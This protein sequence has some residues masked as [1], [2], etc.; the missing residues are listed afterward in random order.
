MKIAFAFLL[1]P[2]A[3]MAQNSPLAK[4]KFFKL[5][6]S[7]RGVY[8]IDPGLFSAMGLNPSQLNPK[9]VRLFAGQQGMLPEANAAKRVNQLEEIPLWASGEADGRLDAGDYFLFFA[10]SPHRP[11]FDS[12][13][14]MI[15]HQQ[16]IYSELNYYFLQ[17]DSQTDGLRMALNQENVSPSQVIEFYDRLIWHEKEETNILQ[18]GRAWYGERFGFEK[19]LRMSYPVAGIN[20]AVAV[21]C[22]M[23]VMGQSF[24]DSRFSLIFNGQKAGEISL[25]VIF[26]G[27]YSPKGETAE[28]IFSLPLANSNRLDLE[29]VFE[30]NNGTAFLDYFDINVS[31]PLRLEGNQ[32]IFS[33]IESTKFPSAIFRIQ[34]AQQAMVWDI[35]NPN[36]PFR[37]ESLPQ[38][39]DLEIRVQTQTFREFVAVRGSNF[40]TPTFS[41]TVANQNLVGLETP[42]LLVIVPDVF[43]SQAERLAAFRRQNDGLSVLLVSPEQIYNEFSSGKQDLVAIRDFVKHLYDK[44]APNKPLRYVLLFGD[45][46]YDFKNRLRNNTNFIPVFESYKSL[47]P[48]FS[49]SSDDFIGLLEEREG[50]WGDFDN[51]TVDVGIG[52]LPVSTVEEANILVDKLIAYSQDSE[53]RG[54]WRKVISFVADDGDNNLHQIQADRL[55]TFVDTNYFNIN[56]KKF[57]VDAFPQ[58]SDGGERRSPVLR[59]VLNNRVNAGSLIV[60]FTGHGAEYGW[61]SEGILDIYSIRSWRNVNRLPFFVTATCEFGRYDDPS[62]RSGAEEIIIHPRGGGIGLITTTRPVFA[63]TNYIVNEAFYRIALR[64]LPNGEM[65]RLGDLVRLTKN[66]SMSGDVNRNFALLGDPSMRLAYPEN[67]VAITSL[68]DKP[69]TGKDTLSALQK[70][71][72]KGEIQ[73]D[74]AI[75]KT[76]FNG[77]VFLQLFEKQI[78][79]TTLGDEGP[80]MNYK[81]RENIIFRGTA[82]V[83][84]GEYEFNFLIPK[85]INYQ[86]GQ[87]RI[88]L[89]AKSQNSDAASDNGRICI[90]SG[91]VEYEPD[92]E[93]P[94]INLYLENKKF[95]NGQTVRS[96][97]L[98]IAELSDQSGINIGGMGV[99]RNLMAIIDGKTDRPLFLN[100]LYQT[101]IDD[102]TKGKVQYQFLPEEAFSEGW[103]TISLVAWDNH[104]NFAQ[105]EIKFRVGNPKEALI[106]QVLTYP[107]PA[108]DILFLSICHNLSGQ[109]LTFEAELVSTDGKL[110]STW[111]HQLAESAA[112]IE[113]LSLDLSQCLKGATSG[114]FILNIKIS[115]PDTYVSSSKKILISFN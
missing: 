61:T 62:R 10:E 82:T 69:F 74:K 81:D 57:Y 5:S 22:K 28:R 91:L 67:R 46:S 21:R 55:A 78:T 102:F 29:L 18:S 37:I 90:G 1:L 19:N 44:A 101:E 72:L 113:N 11:F 35:T 68:N 111:A 24:E 98:L 52:R 104:N 54:D 39:N 87:G 32:L 48:I 7:E 38:N 13:N 50:I 66:A 59:N 63:N 96:T 20:P 79:K 51:E 9:Q 94:L 114:L 47:H 41:G 95:V 70:V 77:V 33:S 108:T 93:A 2:I 86:F 6:V 17:V 112:C 89:Y 60:N 97:P 84:A 43:R 16:N 73:D 64:K 75:K 42:D 40:L 25:P 115:S 27:T 83:R 99:G 58:E 12:K 100:S 3:L 56:V 92:D 15:L 88:S 4:G 109:N 8:K 103:H 106:S 65:P 45:A 80:T 110:I 49:Y 53:S 105:E 14:Q 76:D 107:N 23:A 34:N 85:D 31:V 30:A 26:P 71:S 36:R